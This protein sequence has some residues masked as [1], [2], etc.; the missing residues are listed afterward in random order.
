MGEVDLGSMV[1][2]LGGGFAMQAPARK[3]STFST[4]AFPNGWSR[5]R[6]VGKGGMDLY[7]HFCEIKIIMIP[8]YLVASFLANHP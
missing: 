8:F 5:S 6:V 4:P 3:P 7:H 1:W 2:G